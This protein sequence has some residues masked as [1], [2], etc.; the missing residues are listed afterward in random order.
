MGFKPKRILM[1][2]FVESQF[3]V[4]YVY[5]FLTKANSYE[6]I[7]LVSLWS[8]L[9]LRVSTKTEVFWRHLL[10]LSLKLYELNISN[11]IELIW[12]RLLSLSLKLSYFM[13]FETKANSFEDICWVS[14]S[15]YLIL[16]VSNKRG[17]FW[18]RL[19]SLNLNLYKFTSFKQKRI[20]MKTF[21]GSQL[22]VLSV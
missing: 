4:M 6:N 15:S 21:A 7:C 1:K 8:Y 3:V 12:R 5:E 20:L 19:L 14:V 11:K 22:E 2:T 9:S 10:S 13:S 16:W 18:R 17:F